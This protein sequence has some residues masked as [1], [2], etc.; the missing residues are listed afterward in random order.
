MLTY[1][2]MDLYTF[3]HIRTYYI[4]THLYVYTYIFVFTHPKN[5][6]YADSVAC[7]RPLL[8]PVLKM[9]TLPRW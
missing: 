7:F 5:E 8:S 3:I 2:Y 4:R 1:I 9:Q 6:I